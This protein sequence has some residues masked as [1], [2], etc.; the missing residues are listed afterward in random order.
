MSFLQTFINSEVAKPIVEKISSQE[1][2]NEGKNVYG[3]NLD[4][5]K[6]VLR[7]SATLLEDQDKLFK[8]S[9]LFKDY[10]ARKRE[11]QEEGHVEHRLPGEINS[12]A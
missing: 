4:D 11:E 3:V 12:A 2:L 8:L 9:N 6:E 5:P 1:L 7:M 10:E